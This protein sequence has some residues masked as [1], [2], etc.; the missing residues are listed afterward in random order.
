MKR[1]ALE[2]RHTPGTRNDLIETLALAEEGRID[3]RVQTFRLEDAGRALA[4]LEAGRV[5]GRAVIAPGA[6]A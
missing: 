6:D 3:S 4:E 5:L 1:A 2:S